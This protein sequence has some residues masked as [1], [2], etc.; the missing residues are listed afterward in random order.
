MKKIIS[1]V[2][3]LVLVLG[4]FPVFAD[5]ATYG[6]Q[7]Q[8]LGLVKGVDAEGTLDEMNTL[9]RAQMMVVL[10]R[11]Y[12]V[13]ETAMNFALPSTFT[14]VA[15]DAWYAPY[16]AYAQLQGWTVG[17]GDGT[18]S[19]EAT[20]TAQQAATFLLRALGYSDQ[21][22][23]FTY[24]GAVEFAATLGVSAV[25]SDPLLRGE[26]FEM[27]F[28]TI[29]AVAKNGEVLGVTL[30]VL[31][32]NEVEIVSAV[33]TDVNKITVTFNQPVDNTLA[34]VKLMKGLATY[35]TTK[36]WSEDMTSVVLTSSLSK[37][38]SADYT[39]QVTGLTEE[40]LVVDV[41]V[42][43]E[44]V[45]GVD[46]VTT[47]VDIDAEV[48]VELNV[49]NQ[50]GTLYSTPATA[51][52]TATVYE[53]LDATF[54]DADKAAENDEDAYNMTLTYTVDLDGDDG[55]DVVAGDTFKLTV[56]Y[57]SFVDA[58][59][60]TFGDAPE[61]AD[62]SFGN[63]LPLED[64]TKI[65]EDTD[66]L[67]VEY[68]AVDQYGNEYVLTVDDLADITWASSDLSVAN[69]ADLDV[70]S[71]DELTIDA[72]AEGDTV[73]TAIIGEYGV[74]AQFSMV[75]ETESYV[76]AVALSAPSELVAAGETAELL[77]VA[78]DQF[79]E[80]IDNDDVTNVLVNGATPEFDG[81]YLLVDTMV[82][83]DF[84]VEVT[85]DEDSAT[86]DS[87]DVLDT[88]TFY[89]EEAAYAMEVTEFN[90][91]TLFE[92]AGATATLTYEDIVVVDQYG[93]DFEVA[94]GDLTVVSNAD[95]G[96]EVFTLAGL[97]FTSGNT[98]G[99]E[100]FTLEVVTT[101]EEFEAD[102]YVITYDFELEI[103]ESDDITSY[104]FDEVGTV[105]GGIAYYNGTDDSSYVVTTEILGKTSAGADVVLVAGKVDLLTS[106][107]TK[108]VVTGLDVN[109]TGLADDDDNVVVTLKAF[110]D[111]GAL[112]ATATVTVSGA[113]PVL[114]VVE[115]DA[116]YEFTTGDDVVDVLYA[117]DQ[118]GIEV[119]EQG[120]WYQYN[121]DGDYI[122]DSKS[123]STLS[124]SAYS[125]KYVSLD[126]NFVVTADLDR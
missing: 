50:Y 32:Q 111:E 14:D 67:V 109:G 77:F 100:E 49:F 107:S 33:V 70:N 41:T 69:W 85:L 120:T 39:V 87:G 2:L 79:G 105:Y 81:E 5:T 62:L 101:G 46:V 110:D 12:G 63:V 54:S 118:Y 29:N 68:T 92:V 17:N 95:A 13:E 114:T 55:D 117:E 44:E 30:G 8:A 9:T 80:V 125:I 20:L 122:V 40:A 115:L 72:L 66:N 112:L 84:D 64:E 16:V 83:D 97:V 1:L 60:V 73:I 104:A 59:V 28:K 116:D 102:G 11:L 74:V 52:L 61:L 19:P 3:V 88:V 78:Y 91:P 124:A 65:F 53:T 51:N 10:S 75:V 90:F 7:L 47:N 4:S 99:S 96:D 58:Q 36:V 26:L 94:D 18:F 31:V 25:T 106:S 89:V 123:L 21:T 108:L 23:D 121:E 24:E 103:V 82:E 93:R 48:V 34:T 71:D 43:D 98:A 45:A 22:G 35:S 27:M 42:D 57:S 56:V 6:E 119:V 76:D 86:K 38:S 15:V 37:L 113:D 126:G